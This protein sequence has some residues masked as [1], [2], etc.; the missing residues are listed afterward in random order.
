[1]ATSYL[2]FSVLLL[3]SAASA[4]HYFG[5]SVS[6]V[7]RGSHP[8]G[9]LQVDLHFRHTYRHCYLYDYWACSSGNCGNTLSSEGGA[10]DQSVNSPPYTN[11]WCE[12][13][14]V[15]SR[16]FH[17]DNPFEMRKASCCWIYNNNVVSWRLFTHVDLRRRSDT[18]QPNSS[19][20]NAIMP[21]LRVPYNCQ[22]SYHLLTVDPDG[23]TVKC[24]YG[25]LHHTECSTCNQPNGFHLDEG[26]CVLH[27]VYTGYT[28]VYGFELVVE[29]FPTNTITLTSTNGT[30]T[31]RSPL[32][33]RRRKRA[34]Y[35]PGPTS[36]TAG[37]TSTTAGPATTGGHYYYHHYYPGPTTTTAGPTTT[38][39]GPTS[40]TA[41]PTTTGGHYYYHHYYPGPTSTTAGPTT[42]TAGPTTTTASPTTTTAGPTT[43]TAGPTTTTASPTT[44]TAGPTTTTAGPTT[45]TAGPTTTT[46][47]RTTTTAGPTTT[48]AVWTT[49]T[50]GPT[51]TTAG[52]TTTTT[53][54]TTPTTYPWT[55]TLSKYIPYRPIPAPLSKLPLQFSVLVDAYAPSCNEGE[56]LPRL[57]HPTP[58]HGEHLNAQVNQQF[59][60]KVKAQA[61]Y[62]IVGDIIFSGPLNT[63]KHMIAPGEFYIRWTPTQDNL[64]D[65][66]PI[67][68]IAEAASG[69]RQY[70]S[71][72]RCVLVDVKHATANVICNETS[73]TV[74]LDKSSFKGIH[75]DHL[76]LN[77]PSNIACSL[78]SN[79]THVIGIIPLNECGTQIEEDDENLIF[80]NE[81][82][83]FD[84]VRDIITR[85][86]LWE[87]QFSCQYPKRGNVTLGFTVHRNPTEIIEKGFGTFTYIFEFY[88]DNL[89]G[90]M[91]D[92]N[93]YPLYYE[94]GDKIYMQIEAKSSVNNTVLF[95]ES[96]RASPYD[97]PNYQ[98]TYSIIENGCTVDPTVVIYSPSHNQ[99]F[100]LSIDAFKFIGLHDQVYISCSV[101]L[102]EAG[103]PDTRCFKGC[104]P[105]PPPHHRRRRAAL[106]ETGEHLVSQGPL[107]LRSTPEI[108][109]RVTGLNLNLAFIAGCL[110]AA[111]A[112][113]CG[114]MI[115]KF[116]R[117][118]VQYQPLPT[119]EQ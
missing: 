113:I 21:F 46:A 51:T 3:I 39:A 17:S 28:G 94:V 64:G 91:F 107:R 97:N 41:G 116:K 42:T 80:K 102:C 33:A 6:F 88:P 72:M 25:S 45:T 23:D 18:S 60:M 9:S 65:Q 49:T 119:T 55:P 75:E 24:R 111:I 71:E 5:G 83:T 29:D 34:L 101:I 90:Q 114:V 2:M 89:F 68:F 56:Y 1:M 7:P 70:Q 69:N 108:E 99:Q 79:G 40:T 22:R 10:I 20:K 63:T 92:P 78:H 50:A 44:T 62:S 37:P 81:I 67:C 87:V 96:C 48:T 105:P 54:A 109:S 32:T 26:K 52:P 115:H 4:S 85:K 58:Y 31:T 77:D 82:T 73:M 30:Q 53:T 117:V 118:T 76:R 11:A 16:Y 27:Y 93:L 84:D 100:R 110:L 12:T 98:P 66:A 8:D 103:N 13:E 43:T 19:P 112:M 74:Q 59:E 104:I 86:H 106:I 47:V 57:V 14:I 38:T 61:S 35:Y 95:V 36:T 15:E